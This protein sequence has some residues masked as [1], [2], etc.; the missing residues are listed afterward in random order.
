MPK[1]LIYQLLNRKVL[2]IYP[3]AISSKESMLYGRLKMVVWRS[4]KATIEPGR[5][6]PRE[7]SPYPHRGIT[8]HAL[9]VGGNFAGLVFAVG[10]VLIFVFGM[11]EAR[12][13]TLASVVAGIVGVGLIRLIRKIKRTD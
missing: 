3:Q 1:W 2:H 8:M 11:P 12:W 6:M 13:F 10:C 4:E 7:S 9:S 5:H